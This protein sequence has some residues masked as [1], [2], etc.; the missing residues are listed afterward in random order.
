[1]RGMWGILGTNQQKKKKVHCAH[2]LAQIQVRYSEVHG[3]SQ[4][5]SMRQKA[6]LNRNIQREKNQQTVLTELYSASLSLFSSLCPLTRAWQFSL[7]RMRRRGKI[8]GEETDVKGREGGGGQSSIAVTEAPLI[9]RAVP[10]RIPNGTISC[11]HI[12]YPIYTNKQQWEHLP[13]TI[14]NCVVVLLCFVFCSAFGR[15]FILHP[16][17]QPNNPQPHNPQLRMVVC[18]VQ[19]KK[20]RKKGSTY[21]LH[22]CE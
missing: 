14:P 17:P 6:I 19:T 3:Q 18:L 4:C 15:P 8:K 5:V 12:A 11:T 2:I 10:T 22:V 9:T 1:M 16:H 21:R 13:Q 7:L 20:E